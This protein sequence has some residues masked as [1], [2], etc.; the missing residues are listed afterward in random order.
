MRKLLFLFAASFSTVLVA[1]DRTEPHLTPKK[2]VGSFFPKDVFKGIKV[3][4]I[5]Y[6]PPPP[7]LHKYELQDT[8]DQYFIHVSP[9]SV[10]I[11]TF[12]DRKFLCLYHIYG[13]SVS[14]A[15]IEELAYYGIEYILAYGLAGGVDATKVCGSDAFVIEDAYAK[16]TISKF[17]GDEE[18]IAADKDLNLLVL[19]EDGS[20]SPLSLK[21]VRAASTEIIYRETDAILSDIMDHGCAVVNCEASHIFAVAKD[22]GIK[23]IQCGVVTNMCDTSTDDGSG[24]LSNM[25]NEDAPSD[26]PLLKVNDVVELLVE[27]VMPKLEKNWKKGE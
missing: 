9:D 27:R 26:N 11:A 20:F 14:S 13:G 7:I 12:G 5:G 16:E 1:K 19:K 10:K 2:L 8:K 3:A 21:T 24:S 23:A 15:L 6:C 17:Y 18:I 25:L 22:V 4:V